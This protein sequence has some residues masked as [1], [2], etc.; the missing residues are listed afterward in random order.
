MSINSNTDRMGTAKIGKLLTVMSLP[1]IF[2]MLIQS[3][4]NIVDGMFVAKVSQDALLAVS[5]AFPMQMIVLAFA[6]GIGVGTNSIV[7]RRLGEGNKEMADKHAQSGLFMA[8]IAMVF[9]MILGS[10]LPKLF[11]QAFSTNPEV[12]KMGTNYLTICMVCCGGM[13]IEMLISKTLQ[14]T[15]N[16]LV[17]MLSQ[18]IGAVTNIILDP[19]L[20]FSC[21]LGVVGAAIA[22]VTGQIFAMIF[23]IIMASK[24][25]H[26]IHIFFHKFKI[27]AAYIGAIIKVG[28][29]VMVMNAV[30]GFIV[31]I[32]NSILKSYTEVAI[33]AFGVYFKLQSFVFMPVFGLT[34]GALPILAYNFGADNI[35]RYKHTF[36]LTLIVAVLI[37]CIGTA[38]FQLI[39]DLLMKL[40][41]ADGDLLTIGAVALRNLSWC[42]IP[43]AFGIVATTAYQSIG[44]GFTSLLMSLMRQ[45]ALI[46]PAAILFGKWWGLDG[47]WYSYPFAEVVTVFIFIPYLIVA[48][49]KAFRKRGLLKLKISEDILTED[50]AD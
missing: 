5:I 21:N 29:P 10:F 14:S 16:M 44:Y 49:N 19:I 2:S 31:I 7:A 33:N 8:I 20:I 39:P 35:K 11:M 41:D 12:V 28:L 43:A 15:G 22:T 13:M 48:V 25:K 40:F 3:M 46:I 37:L 42:F 24:K 32:I 50:K 26:I 34:Q 4:Y 45:I 27:K 6:L 38:V 9:F 30:G 18:L 47:L 36:Y 23:A 1:A 17:P